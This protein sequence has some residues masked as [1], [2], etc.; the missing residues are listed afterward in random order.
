MTPR[1]PFRVPSP[2]TLGVM[3]ALVGPSTASETVAE[4]PVNPAYRRPDFSLFQS[5]R[6]VYERHCLVC[7]GV[8]GD[9][10]GEMS[11]ALP[12]KPRSFAQGFFKYRS[13]PPGKLP[14]DADLRRTVVG[15]INGTAMG[16]FSML[17]SK[18]VEAVTEYVKFFSRRWRKPE[19]FAAPL[20]FPNPPE[21]L[22]HPAAADEHAQRGRILFEATCAACH[23]AKGDG[24]GIVAGQLKDMWGFVV[25]P[26]DLRQPHLR[27][28]DDPRDLYRVLTTGLD[29][30]PMVSFA[31]AFT[32]EQR[33][34]IVAHVLALRRGA[35]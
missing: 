17:T 16:T 18:E 34:D 1:S 12:V 13:T 26:A 11:A 25:L 23:G 5:G 14:T 33:W 2:A 4:A 27:C 19:N 20:P 3:L 6:Y 24:K 30:T 8:D 7:H 21:W 29:G 10:K 32:A 35:K 9:G 28:G 22:R 31:E 15:G